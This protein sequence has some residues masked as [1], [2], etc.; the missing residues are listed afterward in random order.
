VYSDVVRMSYH[1][2]GW[3][4]VGVTKQRREY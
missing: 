4:C 1:V 2:P 3:I